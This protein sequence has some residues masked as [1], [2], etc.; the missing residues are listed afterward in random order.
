MTT[1]Q[2]LERLPEPYRTMAINKVKE[3]NLNTPCTSVEQAILIMVETREDTFKVFSFWNDVARWAKW[4]LDEKTS[5]PQLPP[6]E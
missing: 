6:I 1:K 4:H 5:I 3:R 2:Q